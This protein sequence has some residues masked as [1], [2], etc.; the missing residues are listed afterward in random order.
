M[1]WINLTFNPAPAR[2]MHV[3]LNKAFASIEQLCDPHLR[4][5]PVAVA[6]YDSP[7]GA[8]I[9]PSHEAK[10]RG[11]TVGMSVKEG[12]QLCPALTVLRPD[13]NKYRDVHR[14]LKT[15]LQEYTDALIAKSI[16]EFV[17]DLTAC[18]LAHNSMH[19]T[20]REIKARLRA[21]IGE[22][23]TVSIGI[24]PNNFLAKTAAGLH[25]PDGLFE[26][27][28]A[29][30]LAVYKKLR[31]MDLCGIA[32]NNCV[33]L[34][35]HGIYT[36]PDFYHADVTTL[37]AAFESIA[38]YQWHQRLHGWEMD[39]IQFDRK[40]YGNS[41]ALP[42]EWSTPEELAPILAK[43]VERTGFR[44]RRGSY[45]CRG[46]HV[47]MVYRD[48][49]HWH[50]GISL[51]AGVFDSRDIYKLAFR[52]LCSAPARKPVRVLAES[53]FRL[54]RL[55]TQQMT[56]FGET[57]AQ[58][59]LVHALDA[60]NERYGDFVIT[61]AIL[62]AAKDLVPDRISFGNVEDLEAML[63]H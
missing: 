18:P 28:Q 35:R 52:L 53:V 20:A 13:Y 6:A 7:R 60:I 41:Y 17:L 55:P 15:L 22:S 38:G 2:K 27:N 40:S 1:E 54:E 23:L 49:D 39:A 58:A 26:I 43:L 59:R 62:L 31:L 5:K 19:E 57:E 11:V 3:D 4:G 30:A 8:I 45:R 51:Q 16:D 48:G 37:K 9:A 21:E 12:R 25:K 10:L 36:V 56:L 33:R 63:G 34:N 44:M 32:Q 47:A 24:A 46:V 42:Q 50:K 29:N 61:P 14:K